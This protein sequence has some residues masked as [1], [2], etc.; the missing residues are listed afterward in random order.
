[1][2]NHERLMDSRKSLRTGEAVRRQWTNCHSSIPLQGGW[3]AEAV[4]AVRTDRHT[5]L[6]SPQTGRDLA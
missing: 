2:D 4:T 5:L 1:M 6:P 3:Q